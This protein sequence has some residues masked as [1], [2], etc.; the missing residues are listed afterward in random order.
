MNLWSPEGLW[1][2]KP[3]DCTCQSWKVGDLGSQ[4]RWAFGAERQS[5]GR[6]RPLAPLLPAAQVNSV[7]LG[8]DGSPGQG[9]LQGMAEAYQGCRMGGPAGDLQTPRFFWRDFL[10][11]H[12]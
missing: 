11:G 6:A 4:D 10:E 7:V 3:V 2:D 9:L 5:Q 8:C 1:C 12:Q